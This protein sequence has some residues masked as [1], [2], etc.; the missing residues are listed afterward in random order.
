MPTPASGVGPA[1]RAVPAA[2]PGADGVSASTRRHPRIP[3]RARI[4]CSGQ[5]VFFS[6]IA[7]DLS[8]GGVGLETISRLHEGEEFEVEF[9]VPGSER[10][11]CLRG[12]VVW[13]KP[14]APGERRFGAGLAFADMPASER[15]ALRHYIHAAESGG[16]EPTA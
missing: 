9:V 14:V 8:E 3:F 5:G 7:R 2:A 12:K 13:V 16:E 1:R 11:V 4:W 10:G 15:E 6:D